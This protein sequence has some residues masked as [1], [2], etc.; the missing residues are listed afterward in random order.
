MIK[1]NKLLR[2]GIEKKY[3]NSD[4]NGSLLR[5]HLLFYIRTKAKFFIDRGPWRMSISLHYTLDQSELCFNP[6]GLSIL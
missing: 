6:I 1:N 2:C 4:G 3:S 5:F